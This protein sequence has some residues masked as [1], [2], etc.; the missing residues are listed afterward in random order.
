MRRE[1]LVNCRYFSLERKTGRVPFPVGAKGRCRAVVCVMGSGELES[2]GRRYPLAT[3]DAVLLPAEVGE[4]V[5]R[6]A[7]EVV[8]LECGLPG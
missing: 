3:G 4:C 6:P 5:C 1:G 8:V 7:G 2:G